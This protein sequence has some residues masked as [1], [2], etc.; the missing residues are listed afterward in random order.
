[1]KDGRAQAR[2][3]FRGTV[4]GAN[5]DGPNRQQLDGWLLFDLDSNYL[6]YLYLKGVH[7]LLDPDGKEVGR[8][9]GRYVL[10][11]KRTLQAAI[12]A[13]RR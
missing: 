9:E 10:S 1:M 8:V 11:R 5:E 7:S 3:T 6:S 2:V 4:R 12:S 13:T